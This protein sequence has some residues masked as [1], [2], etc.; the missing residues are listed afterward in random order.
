MP[1]LTTRTTK[2][3]PDIDGLRAVAVSAVVLYHA[4]PFLLPGG[5]VGVDIFFVISGYLIAGILLKELETDS[6]SLRAFWMRRVRRLFPAAAVVLATTIALFWNV[7]NP[8]AMRDFSHSFVAQIFFVSNVH[9]WQTSSY[10]DV[11]ASAK[12]LLHTWSLS[13]EEQFYLFFPILLWAVHRYCRR[14]LVPLLVLAIVTS[15]GLSIVGTSRFESAAFYLL[16]FR[17]WELGI[18][19]LLAAMTLKYSRVIEAAESVPGLVSGLGIAALLL[20]FLRF[21]DFTPFPSYTALVPTVG[22]AL[23]I[24]GGAQAS[25]V[26]F[27]LRTRPVVFIGKISYSLYLWHWVVLT[28][29][30]NTTLGEVSTP[31]VTVGV[32]VS[33]VLAVLT[34]FFVECPTRRNKLVFSNVRL[35][36]VSGVAASG[37]LVAASVIE[38]SDGFRD[39]LTMPESEFARSSRT[40][41]L[42]PEAGQPVFCE[43][44]AAD[45]PPTFLAVGD[46][47][48]FA[49]LPAFQALAAERG[50]KGLF[51]AGV[52]C[53]PLVDVV[54]VRNADEAARCERIMR[55]TMSILEGGKIRKL[56]LTARWIMY[57]NDE[58]PD[59]RH[60]AILL[61]GV[62]ATGVD[63]SQRIFERQLHATLKRLAELGVEVYVVHQ[64][65]HQYLDPRDAL[66]RAEHLEVDPNTLTVEYEEHLKLHKPIVELF[67]SY[68]SIKQVTTAES[69]CNENCVM[70]TTTGMPL[71][72][73]DDHLSRRGA[74]RVVPA[75]APLFD[76]LSGKRPLYS[77][78]T[79]EPV[80]DQ[81]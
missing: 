73:D 76:D 15:L 6:F 25:P 80:T 55:D 42:L 56:V 41:C 30:R 17:A 71:Y 39:R 29:L 24:A 2:Y 5:Y 50:I 11:A 62:Y 3:R 54:P 60:Q 37:M 61:D 70:F 14:L 1:D 72:S 33:I 48:N 9:F 4:Y 27:L 58:S 46:S 38:A 18:G 40:E 47:H 45:V 13:V 35:I 34:Y 66:M 69:L 21:N 75:L 10:F 36:T 26:T 31:K 59:H 28:Y 53:L 65:P 79:A 23:L 51:A 16:P 12:P 67:S 78:D 52:G 77:L 44:G 19:A 7:L 63:T 68:E 81:K 20:T 43:I 74:L 57:Y 49:L 64:V 22:T 32:I 8:E